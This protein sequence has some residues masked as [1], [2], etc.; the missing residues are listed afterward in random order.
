[1]K[2]YALITG[3]GTGIGRALCERLIKKNHEVIV[4]E[5]DRRVMS[6]SVC[7]ETSHFFEA[8]H[9]K[10]GIKSP[11]NPGIKKVI[12]KIGTI[13]IRPIVSMFGIFNFIYSWK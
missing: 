9:K 12:T 1:M 7:P 4:L 2:Q 8:M 3:A 5:A 6:R 10:K 13:I 11:K